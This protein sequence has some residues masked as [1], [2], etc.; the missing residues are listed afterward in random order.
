MD[1]KTRDTHTYRKR[2]RIIT[3]ATFAI[4][5]RSSPRGLPS[6]DVGKED[7]DEGEES[8]P[9]CMAMGLGAVV[10]VGLSTLDD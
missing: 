5:A 4:V 7:A 1:N 9:P 8:A 2:E 10:V 6:I 3:S